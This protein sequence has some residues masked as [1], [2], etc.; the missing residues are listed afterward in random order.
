ML[1]LVE[2]PYDSLFGLIPGRETEYYQPD[3]GAPIGYRNSVVLNHCPYTVV[4][5]NRYG[6]ARRRVFYGSTAFDIPVAKTYG[7]WVDLDLSQV[8]VFNDDG[9]AHDPATGTINPQSNSLL[10][11]APTLTDGSAFEFEVVVSWDTAS[12]GPWIQI[13]MASMLPGDY[14]SSFG[15]YLSE[16]ELSDQTPVDGSPITVTLEVGPGIQQYA[17]AIS[18]G[19]SGLVIN[20]S[21]LIF[22]SIRYRSVSSNGPTLSPDDVQNFDDSG[23][24]SALDAQRVMSA[25]FNSDVLR[26]TV[27]SLSDDLSRTDDGDLYQSTMKQVAGN[28]D[29]PEY[30]RWYQA[31]GCLLS[32]TTGVIVAQGNFTTSVLTRCY[33][34]PFIIDGAEMT[35]A[36]PVQLDTDNSWEMGT[37]GVFPLASGYAV[38]MESVPNGGLKEHRLRAYDAN[39]ALLGVTEQ[40]TFYDGTITAIRQETTFVSHPDGSVLALTLVATGDNS[41]NFDVR[42]QIYLQRATWSGAGWTV[43]AP[44][45]LDDRDAG[46]NG[47]PIGIQPLPDG[48]IL[49][50]Y[51]YCTTP[52]GTPTG[53]TWTRVLKILATD[54]SVLDQTEIATSGEQDFSVISPE[55]F[56]LIGYNYYDD[57][58]SRSI[59]RY[60]LVQH[61]D[62]PISG[63][64]GPTF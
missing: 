50:D 21:R 28:F 13:Q 19:E 26:S 52:V 24:I 61:T 48:R 2:V 29:D 30:T 4:S 25:L 59:Q 3:G 53:F 34:I 57:T 54:L 18:A 58:N 64:W 39:G 33:A 27:I 56:G 12:S 32:P 49:V 10:L 38:G 6:I 14:N 1:T 37:S 60:F 5:L 47:Y 16:Q 40:G 36:D 43:S 44:L 15:Y 41:T 8:Q 31:R 45:T 42:T 22:S 62:M 7:D 35:A 46:T 17:G 55:Y 9:T 11:P 63:V 20:S 51:A 23:V